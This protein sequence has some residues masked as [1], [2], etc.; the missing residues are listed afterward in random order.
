MTNSRFLWGASTASYQVEGGITNNDWDFFTRSDQINKRISTI[1]KP[2]IFYKSSTQIVLRPAGDAV[3][4]W[5]PRYY[6]KDFELARN[7]G[8]NTFRISIEWARI[9]PGKDRWDQ[10]AIYHYKEMI[11]TMR[12]S[13]LIPVISLNHATLPLWILTPPQ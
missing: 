13:G 8:L 4:F 2:S 9:E 5:D 6:K 7:L 10:E 11:M 1:T 12:E 3:K